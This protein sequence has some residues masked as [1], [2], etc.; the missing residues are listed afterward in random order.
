MS[1]KPEPVPE[2]DSL[3]ADGDYG[4][5]EGSSADEVVFGTYR[6]TRSWSPRLVAL[7]AERLLRA[8]PGTLIDV[9]ANIGL[10]AIPVLERSAA[11]AL[12][13]EPAPDNYARL[14]RNLAR[15]G[16][17]ARCQAQPLALDESTGDGELALCGEN[18]GDHRLLPKRASPAEA[19]LEARPRVRV[20]CARLD[21]A[22]RGR[23]LAR[24]VVMK[25]DCQGAEARVL[26][27]AA[28]TLERVDFL[29][30]EYWPAGLLRMGDSAAALQALLLGFPYAVLLGH[31]PLEGRL[32]ATAELFAQLA[33]F[34]SDGSDEGFFDL[35]LSR[36]PQL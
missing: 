11:C 6:R 31:Q 14:L 16:L 22:L 21:D 7:L 26:R 18:S 36:Q 32:R 12:A 28:S 29:V 23:E 10:V 34:P 30:V 27:G 15:H 1:P 5:F 20:G 8:G 24:P 17:T 13:F 4:L 9:G 19:G 33:F 2:P 3:L 35:L 25:L